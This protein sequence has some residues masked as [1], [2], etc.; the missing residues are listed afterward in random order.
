MIARAE[1]TNFKE[2]K[3]GIIRKITNM[4]KYL[5]AGK[6]RKKMKITLSFGWKKILGFLY[7]LILSK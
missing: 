1:V 6:D 4:E 3:T 2:W 7:D 5:M